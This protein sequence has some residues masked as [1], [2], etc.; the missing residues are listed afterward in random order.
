MMIFISSGVLGCNSKAKDK[1]VNAS[2][3]PPPV[4]TVSTFKPEFKVIQKNLNVT[5]TLA[6]W[7]LLS[8]SP[9]ANGLKVIGIYAESGESV[10]KGQ[11]L[12][13]LDDASLIAQLA[14]TRARLASSQAQLD[15]VRN[16][17]RSQDVLRQEA[18][19]IQAKASL[20]NARDNAKRYELLYSQGAV[21]RI[22]SDTRKTTFETSQALYNQELERLNLLKAGARSEDIR[23]AQASVADISAQ[24]QQLNVQLSQT[25]V[26]APDSGLV[27]DRMVHL[28]DVS[29]SAAKLFTVI[30]NNRFELQAKIPELDLN[31][32]KIGDSV[33][34]SSDA[35]S[36]L[37]TTGKIRQI[38][39]GVDQA[40]R[41]AIVKIDVVYV[42]G[43]QTGQ[44]IKGVV[45]IGESKGIM[46][47]T[48]SIINTDGNAQVFVVNNSV[49]KARPI[50]TGTIR[51]KLVEVKKGLS[52]NDE[53]INEGAGFIKDGDVVKVV[54]NDKN[55][56]LP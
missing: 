11:I 35:N 26:K 42:K 54:Y 9:S 14:S 47:P 53:I 52:I 55:R 7:D 45:N 37:K 15:K 46:I 51:D 39:P 21:S 48:K 8:I 4:L 27:L 30:R 44:F 56:R 33:S 41:Q 23:I 12:I 29:S 20:D 10:N 49:A 36:S 3:S 25:I 5:G 6:A 2:S 50:T 38:G 22:D 34:I 18:A 19:L 1:K 43:M 31:S 40:S 24:I 13:K 28:G 16:P 32:I 17:N